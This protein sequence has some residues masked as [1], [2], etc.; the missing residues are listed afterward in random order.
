MNFKSKLLLSFAGIY[1]IWG[2]TFLSVKFALETLPPMLMGGI[3]FTIAGLLFLLFVLYKGE[4]LPTRQE[5][6]N[7]LILGFMINLC[8]QGFNFL[9]AKDVPS[10][11]VSLISATSPL[12]II[13]FDRM[14]FSKKN[15][16]LMSYIG[17]TI[18]FI[19]VATLLS[20]DPKAGFTYIQA[21]PILIASVFWAFGSLMTKTINLG[22]S[23]IKNLGVQLLCGGLLFF[24]PAFFLGEFNS[25]NLNN[26]S[27]KSFFALLYL[28]IFGSIVVFTCYNWLMKNYDASKVA[29]HG[30]INPLL[31]VIAGSILGNEPITLKI[32]ISAVIIILGVMIIIFGKTKI[33]IKFGKGNK[34]LA[35]EQ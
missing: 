13:F 12:F 7:G 35:Y 16:P 21:I 3:R 28:I 23:V 15:I 22:S 10:A 2:T 31:A 6:K 9:V 17:L 33:N 19:G 26:V 20:P 29:T 14:F 27:S 4:G 25:F 32:I 11:I 24:I 8:G 18:G 1:I 34:K 5:W 30:F